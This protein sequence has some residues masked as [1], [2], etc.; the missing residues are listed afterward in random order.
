MKYSNR[1][2]TSTVSKCVDSQRSD[3]QVFT[4]IRCDIS[5]VVIAM[6]DTLCVY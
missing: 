3:S 1:T 6:V 4:S 2:D 5:I